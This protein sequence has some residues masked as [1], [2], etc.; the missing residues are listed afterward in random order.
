MRGSCHDRAGQPHTRAPG[1]QSCHRARSP[2]P[3]RPRFP[4]PLRGLR[5]G[6]R[7]ATAVHSRPGGRESGHPTC[8]PLP[9]QSGSA[10]PA[11]RGLHHHP[12]P[13]PPLLS[14]GRAAALRRTAPQRRGAWPRF[15]PP[16]SLG[17]PI[18]GVH[19]P[20]RRVGPP[21]AQLP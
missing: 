12:P 2:Q 6:Q 7:A 14:R 19:M 21:A 10:Q 5:P 3:G 13:P 4:Q 11:T 17:R 1:S 20:R 8:G 18:S 9:Q 15:A 16:P